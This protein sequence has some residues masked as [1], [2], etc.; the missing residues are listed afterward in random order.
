MFQATLFPG[1]RSYAKRRAQESR[2]LTVVDVDSIIAGAVVFPDP[3]NTSTSAKEVTVLYLP[4]FVEIC[5]GS[6]A[7]IPRSHL[8]PNPRTVDAG[9]PT[10]VEENSSVDGYNTSTS[11][12]ESSSS[13]S[14]SGSSGSSTGSSSSSS[15]SSSSSSEEEEDT[16]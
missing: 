16:D 5:G 13:S 4:S 12:E 6:P 1:L 15:D 9:V 10:A 7:S 14:S 2:S 11:E 3:D 8:L